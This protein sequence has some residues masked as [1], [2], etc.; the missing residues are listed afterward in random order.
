[1]H[2]RA[3]AA[4]AAFF[5]SALLAFAEAPSHLVSLPKVFENDF[6]ST[7]ADRWEPGDPRAWRIEAAENGRGHVYSLFQQSKVKTP[8]RSPFNRS[9]IRGLNAG[10]FVLDAQLQS[11]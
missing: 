11:T 4:V 10:S 9:L 7:S 5:F 2:F 6:E 3:L 1:M 8:V